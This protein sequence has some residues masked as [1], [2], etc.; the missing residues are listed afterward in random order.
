MNVDFAAISSSAAAAE[1]NDDA[2]PF[3]WKAVSLVTVLETPCFF[4]TDSTIIDTWTWTVGK[5]RMPWRLSESRLLLLLL[6]LLLLF[7]LQP[8][9]LSVMDSRLHALVQLPASLWVIW[10][11]KGGDWDNGARTNV[12][13][14]PPLLCCRCCS[15]CCCS[16]CPSVNQQWQG[17]RQGGHGQRSRD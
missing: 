12:T 15:D 11:R 6:L 4:S 13:E 17:W 5:R 10:K 14:S 16:T 2:V 9:V 3:Q 7:L 8:T 1:E